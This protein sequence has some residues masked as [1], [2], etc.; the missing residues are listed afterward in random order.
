MSQAGSAALSSAGVKR[1][2]SHTAPNQPGA[3]SSYPDLTQ[4]SV[5]PQP[6]STYDEMRH[7]Y[8]SHK[9][10]VALLGMDSGDLKSMRASFQRAGVVNPQE[11]EGLIDDKLRQ[12]HEFF[13]RTPS[14][15]DVAFGVFVDM[16]A[17]MLARDRNWAALVLPNKPVHYYADL[18][19]RYDWC[20]EPESMQRCQSEFAEAFGSFF[21]AQFHRAPDLTGLH[22]ECAHHPKKLSLH[23][24]II[25][26]A[27]ATHTD[28]V[29]FHR[30]F[31]AFLQARKQKDSY[32]C[33]WIEGETWENLCD[34]SVY[35]QHSLLRLHGSRKP[36][37]T[38]GPVLVQCVDATATPLSDAELLWRGLPNFS[39][40]PDGY[41]YL[42]C[43][44]VTARQG[45]TR[46]RKHSPGTPTPSIGSVSA[47]L[48]NSLVQLLRPRLGPDVTQ[49]Q[50]CE[51]RSS[52]QVVLYC[53]PSTARCIRD[54]T[55]GKTHASNRTRVFARSTHFQVQCMDP[56]C[57]DHQQRFEWPDGVE[58]AT[59]LDQLF[60]RHSDVAW[61]L[62]S[63]D[64]TLFLPSS[65]L[66]QRLGSCITEVDEQKLA[67]PTI[68]AW[69]RESMHH[70]N[71][72]VFLQSQQG[73]GKTKLIMRELDRER[74]ADPV[75]WPMRKILMVSTKRM[76]ANNTAKRFLEYDAEL[77]KKAL[78]LVAVSES[79]S[80][81]PGFVDA[82]CAAERQRLDIVK[83]EQTRRERPSSMGM[84]FA[85]YTL[86]PNNE[87]DNARWMQH[88]RRIISLESF[89]RLARRDGALEV[90][91]LVIL[92]E[93]QELL[94]VLHGQTM[95]GRRSAVFSSL[96]D[97]LRSAN[98]VWAADADLDA[99]SGVWFLLECSPSNSHL[100][101]LFNRRQTIC[102]D[103]R[104]LNE[105]V[106]VAV[107]LRTLFLQQRKK[108][109]IVSNGRALLEI[110]LIWL[111]EHCQISQWQTP[112][113]PQVDQAGESDAPFQLQTPGG[114][115]TIRLITGD[116]NA[117]DKKE[118]M[119]DPKAWMQGI[120]FALTP[121]VGSGVSFEEVRS[122]QRARER[123]EESVFVKHCI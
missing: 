31:A 95:K 1:Y 60:T 43:K 55:Q 105:N 61:R 96:V 83:Q 30:G 23:V 48:Q 7:Q 14:Y 37:K 68:D 47:E 78:E 115:L 98:R 13:R 34:A 102:R 118:I 4:F 11:V 110:L 41:R 8:A 81:Q 104:F 89:L 22:W 10:P 84:D 27:F 103:Y 17:S 88:P 25:S 74:I 64:T 66:K 44:A 58:A 67:G 12:Q 65:E 123:K 20:L 116:S 5:T 80:I 21:Q 33:R 77:K 15:C 100:A 117:D 71:S 90:F 73:T 82:T 26:E 45:T 3:A 24:H 93:L 6:C 76:F 32:L 9:I 120:G 112:S 63:T 40:P 107:L 52:D 53:F 86:F 35:S 50:S 19:G 51:Y 2:G 18:D 42:E 56:D 109:F 91:D 97:V 92:D 111:K 36:G 87:Q 69:A 106:Q 46:K 114:C 119:T 99:D 72:R 79:F 75:R 57:L 94:K 85:D 121:V 108:V 29:A 28:L 38:G 49:W 59:V 54:P 122:S 113:T 62:E 101:Y 39:L 16:V 70:D